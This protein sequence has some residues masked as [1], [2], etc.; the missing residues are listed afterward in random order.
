MKYMIDIE[1]IKSFLNRTD[2]NFAEVSR[3]TGISKMTLS[4]LRTGRTNITKI[5]FFT[6]L[7]IQEYIDSLKDI[8]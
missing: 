8:K 7:K 2:I 6:V 5:K 1:E 4:N 3:I